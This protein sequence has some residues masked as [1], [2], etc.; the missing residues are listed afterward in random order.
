MGTGRGLTRFDGIHFKTFDGSNTPGLDEEA[1]VVKLFEDSRHNLWIGTDTGAV[2]LVG[3][4][5]KIERVD[6]G[7]NGQDGPLV[8]VCEDKTGTVWLRMARGQLY[9]Y[10]E[11]QPKLIVNACGAAT[12]VAGELVY[13][14]PE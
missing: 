11:G 4:E 2:L 5:G 13:A 9:R 7:K 3:P 10:R 6:V 12:F 8:T 14:R 1:K